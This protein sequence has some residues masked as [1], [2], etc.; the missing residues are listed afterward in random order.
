[1][2]R[3]LTRSSWALHARFHRRGPRLP[4][5]SVEDPVDAAVFARLCQ[6]RRIPVRI[7]D[8]FNYDFNSHNQDG[9]GLKVIVLHLPMTKAIQASKGE[10]GQ[11]HAALQNHLRINQL[12]VY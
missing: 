6:A 9:N 7:P 5:A 4:T 3:K 11:T 2:L 8:S 1:M 10:E 12:P